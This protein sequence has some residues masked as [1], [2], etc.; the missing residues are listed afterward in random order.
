MRRRLAL[1]LTPL[2]LIA[3]L[4]TAPA[5]TAGNPGNGNYTALWDLHYG[6]GYRSTNYDIWSNRNPTWSVGNASARFYVQVDCNDVTRNL[7]GVTWASNTSNGARPC[8][9]R[10][11]TDGNFVIYQHGGAVIFATNTY[12][13]GY[14]VYEQAILWSNGCL[15]VYTST[16]L[17]TW[18]LEWKSC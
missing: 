3:A 10:F 4:I 18:Y 5:A 8:L 13:S 16:D 2:L 14:P 17:S 15:G 6:T 11:Q 9:T 7:A 12:H 1:L